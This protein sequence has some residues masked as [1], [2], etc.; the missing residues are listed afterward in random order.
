MANFR[1]LKIGYYQNELD[2]T[3]KYQSQHDAPNN[4]DSKTIFIAIA[5]YRDSEIL[6]TVLSAIK[7]AKN[8]DRLH[9]GIS[10]I[11]KEDVDFGFWGNLLDLPNIKASIKVSTLENVGLGKQR[12]EANAFYASEDYYF[13]IDAHMRF[14]LYWDDLLIRHLEGLKALGEKKPLITGYPRGYASESVPNAVG[15]YPYYNPVSKEVYFREH[16]GHNNVP[17]MRVGLTPVRFFRK[18]G[19]VRHGDRRFTEFEAIALSTSL[20]PAQ[21]FADG[22]YVT[23]VPADPTLRFLEEEQYYSIR[24]FMMGY[25]FYVPRVTGVMHY[26]SHDDAGNLIASRHSPVEEY[27]DVFSEGSYYEGAMG[28]K[29]IILNL[30]NLA[31][32]VRTFKEYEEFAGV[33]YE[34]RE[35]RSPV[36]RIVSNDIIRHINFLTEVYEYSTTEYISWFRENDY[37]WKADVERNEMGN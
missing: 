21:L 16:R 14:D 23:D 28:G 6:P 34:T 36:D 5:C 4:R 32:P 25:N 17:C 8:A 24:S 7:N 11:Y 29:E 3:Y 30:A 26:Y 18:T 37:Y 20:S 9:F 19:F 1:N 13:Q 10:L 31:N 15:Y 27:P 12:A 2:T 22:S 33:N 35:L